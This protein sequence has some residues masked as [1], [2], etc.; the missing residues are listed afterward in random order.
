M[1]GQ[2]GPREYGLWLV[3]GAVLSYLSLLD[4]GVV[5]LLPRETAYATGRADATAELPRVIGATF[6]LVLW[7]LPFVALASLA[8]WM[9]LPEE[10]SDVRAPLAWVLVIFVAAFPLRMANAILTGL[11]DLAFLGSVQI[12]V[13]TVSTVATVVLVLAGVG[14]HSLVVGWMITQVGGG[15]CG[16]VRLKLRHPQVFPAALPRLLWSETRE[17]LGKG[18]WVSV[19]QV[20]QV[21]L[22]GSELLII[23]R[24][25]GPEAVVVYSCTD[26]LG[27]VL[28]NQP[29]AILQAAL[30]A[31]SQMKVAESRERLLQVCTAL[32][33]ATL[34]ASGAIACCVLAVNQS[35]VTRWVGATQFGG[36]PLVA[37][38]LLTMLLR[39]WNS[40][41]VYSIFCF[42]H[43]K[44]ISVT[45]LLDGVVTVGAG[46]L[47]V[48]SLGPIG[49][50][51]G[52]MLGVVLVSL[53]GN[54]GALASESGVTRWTLLRSSAPWAWRFVLVALPV[55]Y[56]AVKVPALSIPALV[57]AGSVAGVIYLMFM[58]SLVLKAPLGI[59]VRPRLP[60]RLRHLLTP[61]EMPMT[62][63][64]EQTLS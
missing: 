32:M 58:M 4:L 29:L 5:G 62:I 37:C 46:L 54:L 21:M 56:F 27:S 25:I 23:A 44:R 28:S 35:F 41:A 38:L 60:A 48:R 47:L 17:H 52:S 20:A 34:I 10:W 1:I 51:L 16:L 7:Q 63:T 42:G 30:P 11:Q 15:L 57:V 24:V 55:G 26:K 53:P 40:A 3:S 14:L 12:A 18:L 19:A 13:W 33:H 64:K 43:E 61:L 31:L 59:Y 45:T 50:P 36:V 8:L 2:L 22:R 9:F 49:A 6:R 39:H